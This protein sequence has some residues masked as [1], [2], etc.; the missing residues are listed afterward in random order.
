MVRDLPSVDRLA[1]HPLL[2]RWRGSHP[3]VVRAARAVLDEE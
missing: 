3:A 1:A 2:E